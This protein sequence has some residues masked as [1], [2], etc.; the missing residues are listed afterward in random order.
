MLADVES[1]RETRRHAHDGGAGGAH[2][3]RRMRSLRGLRSGDRVLDAVVLAQI[4]RAFLGPEA[5]ADLDR[6]DHLVDPRAWIEVVVSVRFVLVDLPSG[7][8]T[9]LD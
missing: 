8:D 1:I 5:P 4:R 9:E 7:A 2:P 6:V 3:Q